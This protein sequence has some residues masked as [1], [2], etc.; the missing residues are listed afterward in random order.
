MIDSRHSR[1]KKQLNSCSDDLSCLLLVCI[2]T[3]GVFVP[4]HTR[5]QMG[6]WL[7]RVA[8]TQSSL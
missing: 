6:V 1:Q 7:N 8:G 5:W 3:I 2:L 4:L